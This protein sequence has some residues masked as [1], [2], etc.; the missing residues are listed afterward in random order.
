MRWLK[1]A[2]QIVIAQ[3]IQKTTCRSA[4]RTASYDNREFNFL[5]KVFRGPTLSRNKKRGIKL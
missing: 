3:R 5:H 1:I 4:K 2:R